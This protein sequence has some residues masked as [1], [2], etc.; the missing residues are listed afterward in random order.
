MENSLDRTV[1]RTVAI[2]GVN[3]SHPGQFDSQFFL[4]SLS[5][6]DDDDDDDND[7]DTDEHDNGDLDRADNLFVSIQFV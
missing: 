5:I 1:H 3:S 2:I 4:S 6:V 7:D